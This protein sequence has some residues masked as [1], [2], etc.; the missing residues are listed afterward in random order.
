[1]NE[2]N[3]FLQPSLDFTTTCV[4][5]TIIFSSLILVNVNEIP[6]LF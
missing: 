6:V 2:R 3:I 5:N 1:M 4:L